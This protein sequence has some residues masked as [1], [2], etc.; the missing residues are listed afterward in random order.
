VLLHQA[1]S[2]HGQSAQGRAPVAY[3][4]GTLPHTHRTAHPW[5]ACAHRK[6][7]GIVLI[8]DYV[9][10]LVMNMKVQ[11]MHAMDGFNVRDLFLSHMFH[12]VLWGEPAASRL[13]ITPR[14]NMQR[15]FDIHARP[16]LHIQN[17]YH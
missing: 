10:K 5:E 7:H 12:H 14:E 16:S 2:S 9:R 1:H 6:R 4:G 13:E 17:V 15:T 11:S 3:V 8:Y